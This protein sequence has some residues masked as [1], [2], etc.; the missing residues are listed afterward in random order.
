MGFYVPLDTFRRRA[1]AVGN[2][3]DGKTKPGL[4]RMAEG[5]S[6]WGLRGTVSSRTSPKRA[7]WHQDIL[8]K[9][10][11]KGGFFCDSRREYLFAIKAVC[12]KGTYPSMLATKD[13]FSCR[14]A[15]QGYFYHTA[16]IWNNHRM[17]KI[18]LK[19]NS[20][21]SYCG[22]IIFLYRTPPG[23]GG[24]LCSPGHCLCRMSPL[25]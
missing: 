7:V 25:L 1:R 15:L 17:V 19:C 22:Y 2:V 10:T 24:N 9:I 6:S 8:W 12:Q 23:T 16:V 3:F 4:G 13:Q 14:T 5:C 18:T 20:I 21:L 11:A